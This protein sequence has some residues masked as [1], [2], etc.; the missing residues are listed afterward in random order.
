MCPFAEASPERLL[1]L[2][3]DQWGVESKLHLCRDMSMREDRSPGRA[4]A[5]V[6]ATMRNLVLSMLR[7]SNVSVPPA[8]ESYA[9][10]SAF[11]FEAVTG[12]S[13]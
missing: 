9:A 6:M 3:R 4:G 10:D 13:L 5:R 7:G 11:T 12:R 1:K 8:R 2:N